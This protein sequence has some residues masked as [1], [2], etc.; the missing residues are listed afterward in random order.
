M[1]FDLVTIRQ[2]IA[3]RIESTCSI[4]AYAF[5]INST[6]Y[7][8]AIVLVDNVEYHSSFGKGVSIVN[9]QVEV[10]T[11]AAEPIPAQQAL[12]EF[13]DAGTGETQSIIDALE[14]VASGG[15]NPNVGS[16]VEDIQVVS[17]RLSPGA[18]LESG[19]YEFTA[20]FVVS[21]AVRRN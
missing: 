18:Q 11:T 7:P 8:R 19:V 6:V 17:V 3:D 21:V 13:V 16:A 15:T 4:K 10:K 20:T 1:A 5:D 14:L 12:M 9:M 2:A